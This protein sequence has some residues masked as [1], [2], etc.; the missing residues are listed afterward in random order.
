MSDGPPPPPRWRAAAVILLTAGAFLGGL[1]VYRGSAPI[2]V[3]AVAFLLA[4][5]AARIAAPAAGAEVQLQWAASGEGREVVVDGR[6]TLP[7]GL[8]SEGLELRFYRPEPL[9]EVSPPR[10]LRG[11]RTIDLHLAWHAE[12]PCMAVLA[13]PVARWTD[14]LGLYEVPVA[15]RGTAL[16]LDRFPPET[17]RIRARYLRRTTVFPGEVPSRQR[18]SGGD[19]FAI[20][21]SSVGDT[22]RQINWPATA[23]VGHRMAN[24][25]LQERTGDLLIVL[26]LRPS[27]LGPRLDGEVLSMARAAALGIASAFLAEKARVGVAMFGE[28]V[29]SVPLGSG[30]L[31]RFR[32]RSA[33]QDARIADVAGPAERLAVSL[34]RYFPKGIGCLVISPLSDDEGPLMLAHLRRRGFDPFVL[35]PSVLPLV[36]PAE[37]FQDRADRLAARLF[38]LARRQRLAA[39]W[40]EAPVIEWEE[41]WS[42]APLVRYLARP[43][44]RRTGI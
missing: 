6:L 9:R 22:P 17:A 33:L 2:L 36:L 1:A 37:G 8:S 38:H 20:R 23:R 42:L 28:Y 29:T 30:R 14:P 4:P 7:T 12:F 40:E 15:V 34:G 5:L 21:P 19:F 39:I 3:L 24:E 35:S 27:T 11:A 18:G 41:Y 16:R 10:I 25:F 26:D 32:I 43:P 13:R 44:S 31:Q